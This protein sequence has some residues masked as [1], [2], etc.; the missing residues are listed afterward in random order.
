M[1]TLHGS[2][3]ALEV[4]GLGG[5]YSHINKP[6]STTGGGQYPIEPGN[7]YHLPAMEPLV[8]GGT[9]G[10]GKS[11]QYGE[12]PPLSA[13]YQDDD[14]L[15]DVFHGLSLKDPPGIGSG[16]G[17]IPYCRRSSVPSQQSSMI[18]GWPDSI[19]EEEPTNSLPLPGT[20]PQ[21]Q[22]SKLLGL[23]VWNTTTTAVPTA[24][25]VLQTTTATQSSS[26]G[27]NNNGS[28]IWSPTFGSRPESEL[29]SYH[30]SDNSSNNGFSPI[31]SP[32][33]VVTTGLFEPTAVGIKS[34]A[35]ITDS[36]SSAIDTMV[37]LYNYVKE[38]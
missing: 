34:T 2:T 24:N 30:D 29:S 15:T 22:S 32:V 27:N 7:H 18:F 14:D 38:C 31:Y 36:L 37:S 8:N 13:G 19:T 9:N 12:R 23:Q 35:G 28:S 17:H 26:Q 33:T 21:V 4:N 5:F 3:G 11:Y 20:V 6:Y 25:N 10:Y 1:T 16:Y